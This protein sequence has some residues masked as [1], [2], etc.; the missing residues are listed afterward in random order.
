MVRPV[1]GG[2]QPA[3]VKPAALV[4][5]R[6]RLRRGGENGSGFSGNTGGRRVLPPFYVRLARGR[7]RGKGNA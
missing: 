6:A 1:S 4:S 3:A 2:G 5:P 7:P